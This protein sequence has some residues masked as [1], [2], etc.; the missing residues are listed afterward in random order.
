MSSI[1]CRYYLE[2]VNRNY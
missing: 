2:R 1:F